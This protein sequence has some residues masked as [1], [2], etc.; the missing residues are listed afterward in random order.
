MNKNIRGLALVSPGILLI[1]MILV[2]PLFYSMYVSLHEFNY[3][4]L[5]DFIW[6]KN[7][8]ELFT[9][10]EIIKSIIR[11]IF[12]SIVSLAISMI[13][14]LLLAMWVNTRK[15]LYAYAIQIL[16]LIP[17]VTS[18]MVGSL[19]WKWI[20][21]GD[22]GLFNFIIKL[23]GLKPV[24][25]FGT[26]NMAMASLIFVI[27]WRTI[28]YSMVMILAGLKGIPHE[29]IEAGRI[30][31]ANNWQM[32]KNIKLPLVKTPFL[33]ASIVLLMSNFNNVT[34]PMAL[35]GGGPANATNVVSMELY[36]QGFVY[37]AFG[38]ASALSFIVFIINIVFVIMYM[39]MVKY[40]I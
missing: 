36:R 2:L 30:D 19:L 18:M 1:V 39:K 3:L 17:W 24:N 34:V 13:L 7:Y 15:G 11:T 27:S 37:F 5:G 9:N 29:L 22:L 38:P 40:D 14:G 16:G 21:A 28:G 26:A 12:L 32:L 23:I 25:F 31:G 6:F 10:P 33:V 35:T 8:V 20:L 4:N